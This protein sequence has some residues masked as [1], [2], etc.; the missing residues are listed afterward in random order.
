MPTS[1]HSDIVRARIDTGLKEQAS[2]I[3]EGM[4]LTV[5]DVLREALVRVAEDKRLP[6]PVRTS[7]GRTIS[8]E[9]K[10]KLEEMFLPE[11][12]QARWAER[13][14]Q[15]R[16]EKRRAR[17]EAERDAIQTQIME[18][19]DHRHDTDMT[20]RELQES[21]QRPSPAL[22]VHD[23]DEEALERSRGR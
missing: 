4:G 7:L 2:R 6:F 3:L 18:H 17:T 13:L 1:T 22:E 23:E 8:P 19:Y 20:R 11:L 14:A 12:H 16:D 10:R 9:A 21:E 5:S 15:L